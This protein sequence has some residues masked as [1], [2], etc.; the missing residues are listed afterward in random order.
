MVRLEASYFNWIPQFIFVSHREDIHG[1]LVVDPERIPNAQV[2][3]D[4]MLEE[5]HKQTS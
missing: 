1:T 3:F 5:L 4:G 2:V